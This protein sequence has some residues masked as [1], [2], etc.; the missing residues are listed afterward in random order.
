MRVK[1]DSYMTKD[2]TIKRDTPFLLQEKKEHREMLYVHVHK[3]LSGDI[4]LSECAKY[5]LCFTNS[6]AESAVGENVGGGGDE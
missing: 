2:N 3:P 6:S 1:K 4:F 5:S